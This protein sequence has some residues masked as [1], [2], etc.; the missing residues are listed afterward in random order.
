MPPNDCRRAVILRL[1][2][3]LA[4][5]RITVCFD[6]IQILLRAE[7]HLWMQ[8]QRVRQLRCRVL[9]TCGIG[10]R[11]DRIGWRA[12]QYSTVTLYEAVKPLWFAW[13]LLSLRYK[14]QPLNL[15]L[16]VWVS[17]DLLENYYLCAIRNNRTAESRWDGGLWFA[18]KLLSLRYKKQPQR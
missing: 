12:G 1:E 3:V 2:T 16:S 4:S 14:K 18:W 6:L 15:R 11:V 10:L 17:C 13:K 5:T 9:K 7:V 8:R